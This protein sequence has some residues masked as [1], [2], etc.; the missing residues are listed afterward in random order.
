MEQVLVY[1]RLRGSKPGTFFLHRSGKQFTRTFILEQIKTDIKYAGEDAS[2]FNT[3]SFR[4]GR[5]TDLAR[6]GYNDRQIAEIG[7]WTSNAFVK[8]IRSDETAV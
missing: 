4:I 3:H 2:K 7:R 8:Y 6:A 5:T 1:I